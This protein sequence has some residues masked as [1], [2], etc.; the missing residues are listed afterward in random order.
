MLSLQEIVAIVIAVLFVV[1]VTYLSTKLPSEKGKLERKNGK[2]LY[3]LTNLFVVFFPAYLFI[4]SVDVSANFG[5]IKAHWGWTLAIIWI[6]FYLYDF[7]TSF[8]GPQEIGG[9][10]AFNGIEIC[11]ANRGPWPKAFGIFHT[12]KTDRT[13]LALDVP[14]PA[15]DIFTGGDDEELP[16]GKKRPIRITTAPASLADY[17][18]LDTEVFEKYKDELLNLQ[19]TITVSGSVILR[20]VDFLT[21]NAAIKN[22]LELKQIVSDLFR[23]LM[24]EILPEMTLLM[25]LRN[26]RSI[27]KRVKDAFEYMV[28][29]GSGHVT[30]RMGIKVW[31]A[32][33]VM[34]NIPK[35]ISVALAELA[36]VGIMKEATIV[37]AKGTQQKMIIEARGL[38]EQLA[39][40]GM[41]TALAL[42]KLLKTAKEYGVDPTMIAQLQAAIEAF[43]KANYTYVLGGEGLRK[44]LFALAP[45]INDAIKQKGGTP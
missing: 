13:I 15:E 25:I 18:F 42:G 27:N 4:I 26:F 12:E 21:Y 7:M 39:L 45:A 28:G 30:G 20:R 23:G 10:Y 31:G 6:L 22:D 38:K 1:S 24:N 32:P 17:D 37:E 11:N 5:I 35:R 16:L 29:R 41:G 40:E 33:T 19:G 43:E 8:V 34:V 2:K 44:E 3:V 9:T 36:K 14:A